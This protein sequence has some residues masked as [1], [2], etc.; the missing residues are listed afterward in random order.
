MVYFFTVLLLY[1]GNMKG[2]KLIA[3]QEISCEQN[4]FLFFLF[5]YFFC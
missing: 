5:F 1:N 2:K 4:V 3:Q